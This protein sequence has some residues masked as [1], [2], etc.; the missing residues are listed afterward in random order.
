MS[1]LVLVLR[2]VS[3]LAFG[4]PMLF[5]PARGTNTG[6]SRG[7]RVPLV[8]TLCGCGVFFGLVRGASG[9]VEDPLPMLC[10]FIGALVALAGS[11][12]TWKSR[13]AL[14][15]AWNFGP[16]AG[17]QSGVV[18][19][20]PYR[21]I[22]HPMSLGLSMLAL[23]EG[24]AFSSWPAVLAVA[25]AVVPTFLWRVAV[26]EKLLLQVF[27]ERYGVYRHRTKM[28]MPYLLSR[29]R[30]WPHAERCRRQGRENKRQWGVSWR[31]SIRMA[32]AGHT[33]VIDPTAVVAPTAVIAGDVHVGAGTVVLAGAIITSQGAPVTLVSTASS[34]NTRSFVVRGRIRV[35]SASMSSSGRTPT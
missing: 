17:E 23:G 28:I 20:G 2:G 13:A 31:T 8:A 5:R 26:E 34:W 14:G 15:A 11:A 1:N 4:S 32:H 30:V 22:R 18:T 9:S 3:L 27:G 19:T 10:A 35:R 24:I 7:S 29:A 12:V 25:A 6:E 16:R 33:P 21:W